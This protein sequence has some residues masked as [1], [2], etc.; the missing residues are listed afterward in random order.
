MYIEDF[1]SD[2][3]DYCLCAES[4]KKIIGAVWVRNINGYG[5]IDENTVEFAISLYTDF[6]GYG[7]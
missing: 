6:R 4:E 7:I 2:K 5:S 3:D 1:G